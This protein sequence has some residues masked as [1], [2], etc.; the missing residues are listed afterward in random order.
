MPVLATAKLG[1][2]EARQEDDQTILKEISAQRNIRNTVGPL[3]YSI[4][5]LRDR[6]YRGQTNNLKRSVTART[7]QRQAPISS[8]QFKKLRSASIFKGAFE[9]LDFRIA[10]EP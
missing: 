10:I 8:F 4:Q 3:A 5:A 7:T 2:E 1:Y 6:S 9:V